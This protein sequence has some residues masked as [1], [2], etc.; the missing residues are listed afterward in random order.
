MEREDAARHRGQ[1]EGEAETE[2]RCKQ[3]QAL[4]TW[5]MFIFVP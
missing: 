2:G 5:S 3:A 1:E 4:E